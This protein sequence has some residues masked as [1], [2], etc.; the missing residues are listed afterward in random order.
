MDHRECRKLLE[1]MGTG[2][3]PQSL[4]SETRQ[5][6][7]SCPNCREELRLV[8]LT[9]GVVQAACSGAEQPL[10]SPWF[11]SKV[12]QRIEQR[13][14]KSLGLWD[15]L[16]WIAARAIPLIATLAILL[17]ILAYSELGTMSN[18]AAENPL[19]NSYIEPSSNWSYEVLATEAE[20]LPALESIDNSLQQPS[21]PA[22]SQKE[23][24]P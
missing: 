2:T 5:H 1:A 9:R 20:T 21:V 6:L 4:S 7:A 14:I 11:A 24:K 12:L 13:Q 19:L 23:L 17:G 15:P 22:A 10:P 16:A 3:L 8:R 18:M